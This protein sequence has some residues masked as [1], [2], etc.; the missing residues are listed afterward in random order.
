MQKYNITIH[1]WKK[2]IVSEPNN[3]S[4][5]YYY[6]GEHISPMYD[7]PRFRST[8]LVVSENGFTGAIQDAHGCQYTL[9][10]FPGPRIDVV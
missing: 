1:N 8:D 5:G 2:V 6:T 3:E 10:D 9:A 7:G 4:L